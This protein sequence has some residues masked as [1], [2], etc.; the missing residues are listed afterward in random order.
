MSDEQQQAAP[1]M[2]ISV[3]LAVEIVSAYVS[4]NSLPINDVPSFIA[5]VHGAINSLR[6][7]AAP[8]V[9]AA[10][11]PAVPIKKSIHRDYLISL[12]DGQ[13]YKTL[14]RH[15]STRGLTPDEYRAKWGLPKDYPM[16]CPA[17]SEHRS[18]LAKQ[19]GLGNRAAAQNSK[20]DAVKQETAPKRSRASKAA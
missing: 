3:E 8:P 12:E 13:K 15:L 19:A 20:V 18:T 1:S 16:V 2:D 14:R 7:E 17:Y 10:P 6:S 4:N 5:S 11:E 9:E